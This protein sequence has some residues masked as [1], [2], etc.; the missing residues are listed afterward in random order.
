VSCVQSMNNKWFVHFVRNIC[1]LCILGKIC[2]VYV[3]CAIL[4]TIWAFYELCALCE[5]QMLM[6]VNIVFI[7]FFTMYLFFYQSQHVFGFGP[8]S[9]IMTLN[10]KLIMSWTLFSHWMHK[11][12]VVDPKFE[13]DFLYFND[14]CQH[15][16]NEWIYI[17]SKCPFVLVPIVFQIPQ[18]N[19]F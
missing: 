4:W 6:K 17:I 5:Q 8:S 10:T 3:L 13:I 14:K 19:L 1:D 9:L 16:H 11:L 18:N 15:A 7:C 12:Q 2:I